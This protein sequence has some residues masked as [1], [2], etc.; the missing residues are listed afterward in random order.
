VYPFAPSLFGFLV[1]PLASLLTGEGRRLIYT[2]LAEAFLTYLKIGLWGGLAL[3]SP[4]ILSQAWLF[5]SPGLYRQERRSFFQFLLSSP[6][7]FLGG[8]ALAYGVIC[9]LAWRFFL[10][11][12]H[13]EALP[14]PIQLEARVSE[15]LSLM[16]RLICAFGF[17][18]QLPVFLVLLGRAGLIQ[19]RRLRHNRKY[20]FL[21][22]VVVA[23]LL[24]PPDLLSPLGL[25]VPLYGLFEVSLLLMQAQEKTR[26][27]TQ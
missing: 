16:L 6:L 2:G 7:L 11:F 13:P 12:E 20:V 8:A 17:S 3:A 25:I 23:A 5:I 22:I 1:R 10:S 27:L 14:L 24:T 9:P 15:Y 4:V 18:F 21:G 26:S 19:S